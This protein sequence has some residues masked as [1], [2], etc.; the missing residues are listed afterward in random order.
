MQFL[1]GT[2]QTTLTA[3]RPKLSGVVQYCTSKIA[4]VLVFC[5]NSLYISYV[6]STHYHVFFYL[7]CVSAPLVHRLY[8]YS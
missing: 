4:T 6:Y 7:V 3:D 8:Y 5:L 2:E 1:F